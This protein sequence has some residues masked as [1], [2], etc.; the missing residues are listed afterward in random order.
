MVAYSDEASFSKVFYLT[1]LERLEPHRPAALIV[2]IREN[3]PY[4]M[5]PFY[6]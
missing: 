3:W 2:R 5:L 6:S 1:A 4:W